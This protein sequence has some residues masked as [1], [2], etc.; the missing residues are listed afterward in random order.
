MYAGKITYI[1]GINMPPIGVTIDMTK[2]NLLHQ[3]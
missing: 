2:M 3:M 1:L